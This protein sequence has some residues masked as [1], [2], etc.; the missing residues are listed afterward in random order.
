VP[1]P[2]GVTHVRVD[3]STSTVDVGQDA[4]FTSTGTPVAFGG[5]L[6]DVRGDITAVCTQ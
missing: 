1:I 3:Y 2:A 4:T 6:L 5:G